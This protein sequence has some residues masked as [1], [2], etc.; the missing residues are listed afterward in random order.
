MTSPCSVQ[1]FQAALY[2][3]GAIHEIH[4]VFRLDALRRSSL[5]R[6]YYG[7]DRAMLAEMA[8]FGNFLR[9]PSAT[10]YCREHPG[11]SSKPTDKRQRAS[12]IAGDSEA[13]TPSEHWAL[14]LHLL[15]V[16]GAHRQIARRRATLAV[17]LTWGL[18]PLQLARYASEV[19][20]RISPAAQKW[21][22]AV[23]WNCLRRGNGND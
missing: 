7:S 17:V 21:L 16:T 10:F 19:V 1:R 9:V 4:G 2:H 3:G 5:H 13:K 18:R 20:A 23:A 14:L 8:L 15:E 12:F 11:R 6:P 22:R